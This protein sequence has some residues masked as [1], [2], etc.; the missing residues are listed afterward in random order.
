M[1]QCDKREGMR[2]PLPLA[3][4]TPAGRPSHGPIVFKLNSL[5]L[6]LMLL[7]KVSGISVSRS[8]LPSTYLEREEMKELIIVVYVKLYYQRNLKEYLSSLNISEYVIP[9]E[10]NPY[11]FLVSFHILYILCSELWGKDRLT[12]SKITI[13]LAKSPGRRGVAVFANSMSG[14]GSHLQS[15]DTVSLTASNVILFHSLSF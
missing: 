9:T 14:V 15:I 7:A 13:F 2:S 12:S 10:K 11:P 4:N 3:H 8:R 5:S 6:G 1:R